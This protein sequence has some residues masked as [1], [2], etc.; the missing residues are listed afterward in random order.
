MS[1]LLFVVGLFVVLTVFLY[2][3]KWGNNGNN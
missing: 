1:D 2:L 3:D